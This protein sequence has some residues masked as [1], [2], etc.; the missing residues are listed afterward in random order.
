MV[1]EFEKN[2]EKILQGLTAAPQ[3]HNCSPKSPKIDSDVKIPIFNEFSVK[4]IVNF[5]KNSQKILQDLTST[6]QT[7]SHSPQSPKIENNVKN[8]TFDRILC[9]NSCSTWENWSQNL[10]TPHNSSLGNIKGYTKRKFS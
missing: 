6:P 3:T 4:T 7:H 5:E 8:F 9:K 1:I 2:A 10:I